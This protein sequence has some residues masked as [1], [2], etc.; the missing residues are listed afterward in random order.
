MPDTHHVRRRWLPVV[1]GAL[2]VAAV[3]MAGRELATLLP[4]VTRSIAS[5]GAAGPV[6]FMAAYA[7][8]AVALIP[9]SLLTIAAGITFGLGRGVAYVLL[10]AGTGAIASF[11]IARYLARERV[12]RWLAADPRMSRIDRAVE[13]SGLK[14]MVL[15]RLSPVFPFGLQN[16]ALGLTRVRLR[17]FVI[18]LLGMVPGT[19]LYVYAGAVARVVASAAGG[20]APPRSTGY[21]TVLGLG[22]CATLAVAVIVTR[23]ARDALRS[24]DDLPP[25]DGPGG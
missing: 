17:D 10:G 3:L 21:Y 9:A 18:A 19:V 6:L 12:E 5:L 24:R 20:V 16:Y 7:L 25:A 22:L 11:L 13:A 15:M 14:I 8:A 1:L 2:V 23:I 4:A